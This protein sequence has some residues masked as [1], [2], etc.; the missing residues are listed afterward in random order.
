MS[1]AAC[2]MRI[3]IVDDH[4]GVRKLIRKLVG[5]PGDTFLE[6]ATGEDAIQA[7]RD[8]GADYVTMDINLPGVNGL[9][10]MRSIRAIAPASRVVI[11]TSYDQ[12]YLRKTAHD[13]G[14]LAYVLKEDLAQLR[15]LLDRE[16]VTPSL[17]N[18]G[19]SQDVPTP[20]PGNPG[21]GAAGPAGE[22][23]GD[24]APPPPGPDALQGSAHPGEER[25]LRVLLVDD[26]EN[27]CELICRH[28]RRCGF[29]PQARRVDT[30]SDLRRAL[31]EETWDLVITDCRLPSFSG[32]DALALVRRARPRTPVICVTGHHDPATIAQ[33]LNAGAFAV[34]SK[35]ELAPLCAAVRRALRPG[36][37][38]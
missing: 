6:C 29:S 23:A 32:A 35:D 22:T 7:A 25:P 15:F 14:A 30:G 19:N 17:S 36:D 34:I 1:L 13:A 31:E 3:M 33:I 37:R 5:A 18:P 20:R 11:V 27:D 16:A 10:A 9:E 8:F 2:T 38:T 26:S 12:P 24:P 28:L 21:P 4:A